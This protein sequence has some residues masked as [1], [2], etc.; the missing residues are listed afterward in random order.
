MD[1]LTPTSS[2]LS[3]NISPTSPTANTSAGRIR[4]G[5][6]LSSA[7]SGAVVLLGGAVA[8]VLLA[9]A[10]TVYAG[11]TPAHLPLGG[12]KR[13][14]AIAAALVGV[15]LLFA[16]M[17][18]GYASAR[19]ARGRGWLQGLLAAAVAAVL[20][21]IGLGVAALLRPGPGLHIALS[22]PAGYPRIHLLVPRL[23]TAAA[24]AAI[25]LTGALA[26]GSLGGSWHGRLERR[27][28]TR[29][30]ETQ[31][32]RESFKDLRAALAEPEPIDVD[33]TTSEGTTF[34]PSPAPTTGPLTTPL[35]P[36]QGASPA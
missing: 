29:E 5:V 18:G 7:F 8:F 11:F 31:V 35:A 1:A 32:A 26:G 21:A 28:A 16:A 4:G 12:P 6:S 24:T 3:S 30:Q 17:W 25:V 20:A 14:G 13:T 34:G 22:L 2:D 27:A 23:V 9:R 36:T 33:A 19:M 10:I 15:G